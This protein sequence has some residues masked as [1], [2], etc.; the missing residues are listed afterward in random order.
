VLAAP[1]PTHRLF[2]FSATGLRSN[3]F[4]ISIS[5]K[6]IAMGFELSQTPSLG[7]VSRVPGLPLRLLLL[8]MVAVDG[9][10]V[11]A[12]D[13]GEDLRL[14]QQ[15]PSSNSGQPENNHDTQ[16][17]KG[18]EAG[19]PSTAPGLCEALGAAARIPEPR[20]INYVPRCAQPAPIAT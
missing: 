20:P 13:V 4:Y 18:K 14:L 10:P 17:A 19:A 2:G 9:G 1:V 16:Q 5:G 6:A 15:Q 7:K 3:D 12:S 8:A 11:L